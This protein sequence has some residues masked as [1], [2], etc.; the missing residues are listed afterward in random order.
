MFRILLNI[1]I[2]ADLTSILV[3]NLSHRQIH[4]DLAS[5]QKLSHFNTTSIVLLILTTGLSILLTL[6]S[7]KKTITNW[8]TDPPL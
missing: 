5:Q 6:F 8:P 3:V 1:F 4:L 2:L 7:P